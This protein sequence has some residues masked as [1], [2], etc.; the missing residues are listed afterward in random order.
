M[1]DAIWGKY[2]CVLCKNETLLHYVYPKDS[3]P[4]YRYQLNQAEK[5]TTLYG[6]CQEKC[7]PPI[8]RNKL[9]P[10]FTRLSVYKITAVMS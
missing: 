8:F 7:L 3:S 5:T 6:K 4:W 1:K 2:H 10:L 9:K